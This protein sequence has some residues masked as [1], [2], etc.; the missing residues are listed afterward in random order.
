MRSRVYASIKTDGRGLGSYRR[1]Q[2][3][4][5]S[6]KTEQMDVLIHLPLS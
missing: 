4:K 2:D 1:E 3:F 6:A 5:R